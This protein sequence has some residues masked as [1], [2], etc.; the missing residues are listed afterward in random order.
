MTQELE[1]Y[2]EQ[3]SHVPSHCL[4]YVKFIAASFVITLNFIENW[5]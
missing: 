5:Q 2:V 3:R 1:I 4:G